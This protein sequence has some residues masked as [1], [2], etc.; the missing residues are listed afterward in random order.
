MYSVC[1]SDPVAAYRAMRGQVSFRKEWDGTDVKLALDTPFFVGMA[2]AHALADQE[3]REA[4]VGILS[5]VAPHYPYK[6]IEQIFNEVHAA[7]LHAAEGNAGVQL[8][9]LRH[10][11]FSMDFKI[12]SIMKVDFKI[13]TRHQNGENATFCLNLS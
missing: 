12:S 7:K 1:P 2:E 11:R 10:E 4:K 6:V 8:E 5:L 3:P 13:L 9:R